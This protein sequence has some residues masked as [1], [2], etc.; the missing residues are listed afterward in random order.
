MPHEAQRHRDSQP[1]QGSWPSA[2]VPVA[3]PVLRPLVPVTATAVPPPVPAVPVSLPKEASLRPE[4]QTIH[5]RCRKQSPS[6]VATSCASAAAA[7]AAAHDAVAAAQRNYGGAEEPE[8]LQREE[9]TCGDEAQEEDEPFFQGDSSE[10]EV[11]KEPEQRAMADPDSDGDE[12]RRLVCYPVDAVASHS[13]GSSWESAGSSWPA[14]A[15]SSRQVTASL[16][17][18]DEAE[19]V[20]DEGDESAQTHGAGGWQVWQ[21]RRRRRSTSSERPAC[22]SKLVSKR[23]K[24]RWPNESGGK[25]WQCDRRPIAKRRRSAEV[26]KAKLFRRR[27]WRPC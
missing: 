5:G 7:V 11:L 18:F 23:P 21:L 12:L 24:P 6:R 27:R 26:L 22:C 14:G 15:S 25:H 17:A 16:D 10:Q 2:A 8:H 19:E 1:E 4:P 9:W 20:W 13:V 3:A